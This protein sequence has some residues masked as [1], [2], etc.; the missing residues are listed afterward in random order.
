MLAETMLAEFSSTPMLDY[1]RPEAEAG[2]REA[3][4]RVRSKFGATYPLVIGGNRTTTKET[5][6]SGIGPE[7]QP[8]RIAPLPDPLPT[9]VPAP[10]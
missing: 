6:R 8:S 1:A 9:V 4:E 7:E 2:M 3:I 10:L 5:F